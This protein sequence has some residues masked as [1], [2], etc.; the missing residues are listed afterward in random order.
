MAS[1]DIEWHQYSYALPCGAQ[2]RVVREIVH[3]AEA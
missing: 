1:P 2:V 3:L